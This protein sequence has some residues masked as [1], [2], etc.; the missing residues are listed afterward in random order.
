M[1]TW[2][3]ARVGGKDPRGVFLHGY[4]FPVVLAYNDA[5]RSGH[6]PRSDDATA[7]MA[8]STKARPIS[9]LKALCD[10][11]WALA[12]A[13]AAARAASA[14]DGCWSSSTASASGLR[15]GTGATLPSTRRAWRT[16]PA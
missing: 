14:G 13:A 1:G 12:R 5:T 15:R 8:R 16:R 9:T 3:A 11:G 10:K 2:Q 6:P 7:M 4:L